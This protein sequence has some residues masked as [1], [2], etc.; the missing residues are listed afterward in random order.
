MALDES[1]GGIFTGERLVTDEALFSAD[2]ARHLVA[3]QFAQELVRG[4]KVLDAGCG[5]G[6]GTEL[7]ARTAATAL[8]VD[9][10]EETIDV[11]KRRYQRPNLTY[12]A[13]N[14]D[15][16][17]SL[18]EKFDAVCHF[19]VIEHL[20]DPRPFLLQVRQVLTPG[21]MLVL[22]TPNRI[23]SYVENPYHVH[24]YLA[25][26]LRNLL[27]EIFVHVEMRGVRGSERVMQFERARGEQANRILRLDP[28][29]LRRFLPRAVIEWAYAKLA[30]LVRRRIASGGK[31]M[32]Q[33]SPEDFQI[34]DFAEESLDLLAI[35]RCA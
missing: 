20:P 33:I 10:S 29:G 23:F 6:Y 2:L 18:G 4:K 35:C 11:A 9:R 19:Q 31:S 15:H 30:R 5:D 7:L 3:Y 27:E 26:E 16:L 28:L 14:L 17:S 8:G 13:C 24:E 32:L 1:G 22:T 34:S 25:D 12:K 21:G